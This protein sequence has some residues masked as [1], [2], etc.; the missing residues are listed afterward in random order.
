MITGKTTRSA[1]KTEMWQVLL[2][3][4]IYEVQVSFKKMK[5]VRLRVVAGGQIRLSAPRGIDRNWLKQFLH[6]GEAWILTNVEKMRQRKRVD[7]EQQPLTA[8]E[9]KE[10]L[11]YLMPMVE[12]W[13]PVVASHSV[14]MPHVTV[15]RM[16][17]RFGS[18]SVGRGRITLASI[19]LDVPSECA[20]YVVL[21]ELTHF[22][23][24]NH[25]REFY[26]F[27]ETHMPD[28]RERDRL[29]KQVGK[30]GLTVG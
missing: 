24:P 12:Q 5:T 14:P 15:R 6:E 13:Y 1:S 2:G 16:H 18:C 9:R 30:S 19:L 8:A 4:Q 7:V 3:D 26:Q 22:L 27:I 23:Y 11:A 10:A 21:H 29:L 20:E 28:W 25:G 17:S